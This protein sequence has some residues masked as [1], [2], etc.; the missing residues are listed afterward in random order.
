MYFSMVGY[1]RFY[2]EKED[3]SL[4]VRIFDQIMPNLPTFN[5][6]MISF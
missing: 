1:T 2:P 3:P 6:G 5:C 4:S